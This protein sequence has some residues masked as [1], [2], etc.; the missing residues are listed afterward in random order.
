[1][2]ESDSDVHYSSIWY[3]Q[4]SCQMTPEAMVRNRLD[5]SIWIS[6]ANLSIYKMI[7]IGYIHPYAS[8]FVETDG[9]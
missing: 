5:L 8:I 7:N 6:S 3:G 4:W 9:V 1:M 2:Y